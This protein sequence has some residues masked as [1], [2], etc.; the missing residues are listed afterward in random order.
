MNAGLL[1]C[2]FKSLLKS[3]I[4]GTVRQAGLRFEQIIKVP[5]PEVSDTTGDTMKNRS[6]CNKNFFNTIYTMELKPNSYN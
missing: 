5:N 6:L 1:P 2:T 3:S 4:P